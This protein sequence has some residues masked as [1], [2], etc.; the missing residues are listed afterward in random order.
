MATGGE[1]GFCSRNIT[2]EL[3]GEMLGSKSLM[4]STS[5]L[6]VTSGLMK[7][8]SETVRETTRGGREGSGSSAMFW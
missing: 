3:A 2:M 1:V 4:S 5:M 7:L 8:P 6:K